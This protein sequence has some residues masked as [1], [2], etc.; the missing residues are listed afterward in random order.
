MPDLKF[1]EIG[2]SVFNVELHVC[3]V[4]DAA[5]RVNFREIP[6]TVDVVSYT[7]EEV[8]AATTDIYVALKNGVARDDSMCDRPI[9]GDR[10]ML[11]YV[12][13][14]NGLSRE[15]VTQLDHNSL[16]IEYTQEVR[17]LMLFSSHSCRIVNGMVACAKMSPREKSVR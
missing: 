11:K 17:R 12:D 4:A 6:P 1:A 5:R 9:N 13:N 10:V 16:R 2:C 15:N 14:L 7:N 8:T 3:T